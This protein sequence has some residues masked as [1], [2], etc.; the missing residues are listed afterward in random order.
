MIIIFTVIIMHSVSL[1][2][3]YFFPYFNI[4]EIGVWFTMKIQIFFAFLVVYGIMSILQSK[5]IKLLTS[6]CYI[7]K[8]IDNCYLNICQFLPSF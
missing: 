1:I 2:P 6:N 3:K 8:F 7:T 4:F 5:Q